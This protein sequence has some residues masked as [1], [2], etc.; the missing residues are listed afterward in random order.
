MFY[1]HMSSFFD[2]VVIN[3][4]LAKSWLDLCMEGITCHKMI[5]DP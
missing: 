5:I 4:S 3:S 2:E 1:K